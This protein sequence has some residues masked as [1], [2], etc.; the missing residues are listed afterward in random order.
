M[1]VVIFMARNNMLHVSLELWCCDMS[2]QLFGIAAH[3]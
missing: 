1:L 3:G 2:Q